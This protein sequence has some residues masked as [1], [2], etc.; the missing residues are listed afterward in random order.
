M[1]LSK[2][3]VLSLRALAAARILVGSGTLLLPSQSAWIFGLSPSIAAASGAPGLTS[4]ARLFGVRDMVMGGYL[5]T[6]LSSFESSTPATRHISAAD[7]KMAASEVEPLTSDRQ[8]SHVAIEELEQYSATRQLR[9]A[10]WLGLMCDSVDV[11][12]GLACFLENGMSGQAMVLVYGGAA[13]FASIGAIG[14][15]AMRWL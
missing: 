7:A 10:I 15:R 2:P 4:L 11:C 1:S 3:I 5:W 8:A 6:S 13:L 14:L 9:H 12:G